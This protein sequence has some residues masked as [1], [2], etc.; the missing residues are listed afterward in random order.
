MS[1]PILDARMDVIG[2]QGKSMRRSSWPQLLPHLQVV[3][4]STE[5]LKT[6]Q[7]GTS[8]IPGFGDSKP[9]ATQAWQD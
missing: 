9:T 6:N 8:P 7:E 1:D 4:E 3:V 5:R 2:P